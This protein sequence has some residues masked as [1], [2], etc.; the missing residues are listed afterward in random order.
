MLKT[1]LTTVLAAPLLL[2]PSASSTAAAQST[3]RCDYALS[4][5][6]SHAAADA[7]F[8]GIVTRIVPAT[9]QMGQTDDDYDQTA[10]VD[11]EK[12]YKGRRRGHIVLRQLGSRHAQKF[13]Y[14]SRY[15]FYANYDRAKKFWEVRPCGSTRMAA[16]VQDDLRFLDGLPATAKR[17]RVAGEIVLYDPEPERAGGAHRMPG[18]KVRIV[19]EGGEFEAVTDANG[20][21]EIYDLPPGRYRIQPRVPSGLVFF[22]ALHSGPFPRER[23]RTLEFELEERGCVGV[24]VLYVKDETIKKDEPREVGRAGA[25]DTR[26]RN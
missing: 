24:T 7:V 9:F 20:V 5:C 14:G 10:Y 16:Y 23:A 26:A 15:L 12:V 2:L 19:G 17:S 3:Q 4:P 11:V 6:E 18:V 8:V 21:Y 25:R 13:I 1:F 22:G